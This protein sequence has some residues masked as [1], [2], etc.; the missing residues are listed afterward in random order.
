MSER[1]RAWYA[2]LIALTLPVAAAGQEAQALER[3]LRQLEVLRRDARVTL[4]R[5]QAAARE[6]L[7]TVRAGSLVVV[8]R[9][10]DANFVGQA[11]RIAWTR[12]DSLYGAAA[13]DLSGAP[14]L[15]FLQGQPITDVTP[16]V[17]KLQRVMGPSD[18]TPTDAAY[19]LVRAGSVALRLKTDSALATWLGPQLLHDIALPVMNSRVYVELV[20]APS[21]AVRRC[22]A[23][24][25]DACSAAL[26]IVEG[27]RIPIWY[28]AP[29]RRVLVRQLH[30]VPGSGLRPVVN[31]CVQAGSDAACLDV[32]RALQIELPLS[33]DARQ[34]MAR[35]A[36]AAGGRDAFRRLSRSAG[37]PLERRL[38]LAGGVPLDSLLR[39]WRDQVI[40]ARPEPVT[41][42]A[43]MG[44]AA[45]AWSL[46]FGL[47][48]LRST[49]WR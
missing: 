40:A 43:S 2:V 33:S 9:P 23:G 4:A 42:A 22:Y 32:L 12:L 36:L 24:A 1:V 8:I 15:F 35:L 44:W 41:M 45:L 48:A 13:E 11:A 19:Q 49:R 16:A 18:A 27:D 7:D 17:A 46:V 3:R 26:G 29:E 28:D 21:I 37:Q 34:S 10:A 6:P 5:A 30:D 31:A 47:L 20:T 25:L 38:G 39:Q 14:L